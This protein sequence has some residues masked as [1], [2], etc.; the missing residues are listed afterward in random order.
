MVRNLGTVQRVVHVG[1]GLMILGLYGA[2]DAP[3]KYLTL[4]GLLVLGSGL[5]GHCPVSRML[6]SRRET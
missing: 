3:W 6:G 2:L 4:V 1:V 5:V